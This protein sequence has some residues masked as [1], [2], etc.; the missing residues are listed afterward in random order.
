MNK[1]LVLVSQTDGGVYNEILFDVNENNKIGGYTFYTK[2]SEM[3]SML[4][5]ECK[6]RKD[7]DLLVK[8]YMEE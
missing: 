4:G 1:C 6:S 3:C 2:G 7:W 8:P 5:K